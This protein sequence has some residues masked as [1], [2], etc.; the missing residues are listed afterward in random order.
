MNFEAGALSK[1]IDKS[2]VCPLLFHL[3][4]SDISDSPILQFQMANVEKE[5][6][7][8]LFKSINSS[9]GEDGLDESRLEKMF[10]AFWPE[11]KKEF[12]KIKDVNIEDNKSSNEKSDSSEILEEMLELLRY[13][14][15]LLK[16]PDKILPVDYIQDI[17]LQI[18]KDTSKNANNLIPKSALNQLVHNEI[19]LNNLLYAQREINEDFIGRLKVA[20]GEYIMSC[21]RILKYIG[22]HYPRYNMYKRE[23]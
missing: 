7:F 22:V 20:V 13:Q 6:I 21:N 12:D 15:M 3:K 18:Q 5:D 4:P 9:L 2:K 1:A 17:I 16:T 10:S 8:K 23:E 14:Q 19:F 11:M